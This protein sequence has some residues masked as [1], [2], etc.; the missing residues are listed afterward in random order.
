MRVIS[1]SGTRGSGKTTVIKALAQRLC[2]TD[3]KISIINNEDGR[4]LYD[5]AF[6]KSLNISVKHLRGG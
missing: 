2:Q 6:T 1:I 4:V 3:K 5:E